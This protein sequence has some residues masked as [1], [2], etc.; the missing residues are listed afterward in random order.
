M[1]ELYI[2]F[3]IPRLE[4]ITKELLTAIDHDYKE[5]KKP[6][7]FT[8]STSYMQ[9]HCP[10]FMSWLNPKLK[11]PV[12]LFRYYVTPPHQKLG[13]HIDGTDPR[14]PFGL[15]IPLIGSK[16]TFHSYYDTEPDNLEY[17]TLNGYLGGTQP[18]DLSK[19]KK[20]CDLEIT[21]PYIMNNEVLH[22]VSNESD[23]YRVMFTVR[24]GIHKTLFRNV[25]DVM[26]TSELFLDRT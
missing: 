21:R 13:A 20:I 7:A 26:D 22:S 23:E 4:E 12:R 18:K 24:W 15:N 19:I 11:T 17:K 6:H 8:Y 3:S 9:K 1:K 16:N 2:P 10:L 5:P 14:V 25:E